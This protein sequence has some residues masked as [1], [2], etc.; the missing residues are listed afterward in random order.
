M[1]VLNSWMSR[2]Y[3]RGLNLALEQAANGH[4]SDGLNAGLGISVD[5]VDADIVLAIAS[6]SK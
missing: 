6:G 5:L 4:F 3:L 1:V 2:K